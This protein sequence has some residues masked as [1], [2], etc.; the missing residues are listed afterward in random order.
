MMSQNQSPTLEG[1]ANLNGL[2]A[3]TLLFT[4][5]AVSQAA[6][7]DGI[8]YTTSADNQEKMPGALPFFE[9]EHSFNLTSRCLVLIFHKLLHLYVDNNEV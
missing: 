3:G 4:T 2:K 5:P 9:T 8:K 6:A 1:R 7:C